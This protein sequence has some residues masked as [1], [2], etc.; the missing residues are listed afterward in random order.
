M[1]TYPAPKTDGRYQALHVPRNLKTQTLTISTKCGETN[2]LKEFKMSDADIAC[3]KKQQID[4]IRLQEPQTQGLLNLYTA[5]YAGSNP[6]PPESFRRDEGAPS[7]DKTG[8]GGQNVQVAI[9]ANVF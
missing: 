1:Q 3:S 5:S 4:I 6:K 7:G 8:A 9:C 2:H